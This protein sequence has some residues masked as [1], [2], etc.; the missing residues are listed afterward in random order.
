MAS[1]PAFRAWPRRARPR[2]SP[3]F[4]PGPGTSPLR[5][6]GQWHDVLGLPPFRE[7]LVVGLGS[8]GCPPGLFRCWAFVGSTSSPTV[9]PSSP[10]VDPI[11]ACT[12]PKV[13]SLGLAWSC[14]RQPVT[15]TTSTWGL[16]AHLLTLQADVLLQTA[17]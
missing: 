5:I 10:T 2:S 6:G 12:T 1:S 3:R 16:P 15:S 17:S 9:G 8:L 11:S 4:I 7:A 13:A 14:P